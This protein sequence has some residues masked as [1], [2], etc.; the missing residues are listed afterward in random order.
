MVAPPG[1]VPAGLRARLGRPPCGWRDLRFWWTA[2]KAVAVQYLPYRAESGDH[3][4]K[5]IP[6]GL[7]SARGHRATGDFGTSASLSLMALVQDRPQWMVGRRGRR[8]GNARVHAS[9]SGTGYESLFATR[10]FVSNGFSRS[11]GASEHRR[12]IL[13]GRQHENE[14]FFWQKPRFRIERK[15][16]CET[17]LKR[18]KGQR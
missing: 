15:L 6:R 14:G 3:W 5:T 4:E 8:N 9:R 18:E 2:S 1:K 7:A 10:R 12:W 17:V 13:F 11:R 16:L